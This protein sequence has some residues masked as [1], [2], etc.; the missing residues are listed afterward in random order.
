MKIRLIR[1]ALILAY[2]GIGLSGHFGN[3]IAGN[4]A[5]TVN[6]NFTQSAK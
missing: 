2:I 5:S 6:A 4:A 3:V 1:S